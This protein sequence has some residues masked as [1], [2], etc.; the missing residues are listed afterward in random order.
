MPCSIKVNALIRIEGS[1]ML[2]LGE[3]TRCEPHQ[4]GFHLGV[5]I[6]H[7]LQNLQ[8]LENLNRALLEAEGKLC[9]E[10]VPV[11][12]SRDEGAVNPLL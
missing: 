3:V 9:E 1:N 7:S 5:L 6:R 4:Q 8:A 10:A 11:P 2:L 12:V